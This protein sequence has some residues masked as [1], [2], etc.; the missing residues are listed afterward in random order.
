MSSPSGENGF[1]EATTS[2]GALDSVDIG[3][4][5]DIKVNQTINVESADIGLKFVRVTE[6]SRCPSNVVCVWAGQ[7][8]ILVELQNVSAG[9]SLGSAIFTIGNGGQGNGSTSV[10]NASMTETIDRYSIKLLDVKPY[11]VST[12][13]IRPS[14][15]VSTLIVSNMSEPPPVLVSRG[16]LVKASALSQFTDDSGNNNA[17]RVIA[18]IAGWNIEKGKGM[19]V[20]FSQ[21]ISD[22]GGS[23]LRDQAVRRVIAEFTPASSSSCNQRP[24]LNSCIDGLITSVNRNDTQ[25]TTGSLIHLEIDATKTNLFFSSS[26][27]K[28]GETSAYELQV[29]KFRE[30]LRP[31]SAH[32]N[33]TIIILKEGQRDGPLLVQKI[34]SDHVDGLNFIEYPVAMDKGSPITLR[35]GEKASNGCTVTLTLVKIEGEDAAAS[36]LFAKTVDENR[37]CPICWFQQALMSGWDK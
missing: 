28:K 23:S 4:P 26:T 22:N 31:Y 20:I 32:D 12:E 8:S 1:A 5:F 15:Y 30:W 7:V 19:A 25:V 2:I 27:L 35:I 21:A 37:S 6:D 14:D 11:P 18:V 16:I 13:T 9:I 33:S 17:T 36:A 29:T 3:Q 10:G 34:Y 24:N